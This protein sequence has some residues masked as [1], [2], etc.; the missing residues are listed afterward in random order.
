LV[1]FLVNKPGFFSVVVS[2]FDVLSDVEHG[3][4]DDCDVVDRIVLRHSDHSAGD[5]RLR[6]RRHVSAGLGPPK[7]R[8]NNGRRML[9]AI[10]PLPHCST[11]H[12]RGAFLIERLICATRTAVLSDTT[13]RRFLLSHWQYAVR[14][15]D[16]GC[17][18]NTKLLCT[19]CVSQAP[20][21]PKLV[22]RSG[23]LGSLRH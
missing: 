16:T 18:K 13:Y 5:C 9:A 19:R 22:V 8:T 12:W 17:H 10:L 15:W 6:A 20:I 21:T 14:L 3:G 4:G 1:G 23:P 11:H 2:S 7:R